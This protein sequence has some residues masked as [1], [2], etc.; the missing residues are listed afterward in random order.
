MN[1]EGKTKKIDWS[2]EIFG[3]LFFVLWVLGCLSP[4]VIKKISEFLFP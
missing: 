4:D 2:T 3:R 1:T